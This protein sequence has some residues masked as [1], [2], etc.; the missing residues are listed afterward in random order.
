MKSLKKNKKEKKKKERKRSYIHLTPKA[1]LR[2]ACTVS[3]GLG[4]CL[5]LGSH[6]PKFIPRSASRKRAH[7]QVT[8]LLPPFHCHS[9]WLP[10]PTHL[11]T[12]QVLPNFPL[13]L[14]AQAAP[15]AHHPPPPPPRPCT[16][17]AVTLLLLS[18]SVPGISYPSSL[19][20]MHSR[21]AA[22]HPLSPGR[23]P[24]QGLMPVF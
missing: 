8:P 19:I 9:K 20:P 23:I 15:K 22:L 3:L 6:A 21:R 11:P 12:S 24:Q 7:T 10:E 2:L 5:H 13:L 16:H 4:T 14:A 1:T 18:S 17:P